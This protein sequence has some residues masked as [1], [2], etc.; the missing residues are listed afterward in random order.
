MYDDLHLLA[1]LVGPCPECHEGKLQA[2]FDGEQTNF[3]CR[4]CGLCWHPELDWVSRVNPST[5]PGCPERDICT[6]PSRAY[7]T[8]PVTARTGGDFP[9]PFGAAT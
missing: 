9:P 1:G 5:C 2:N 3:L 7:G 4:S 8:T 6:T